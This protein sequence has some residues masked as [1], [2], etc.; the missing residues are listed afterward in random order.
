MARNE[1]NRSDFLVDVFKDGVFLKKIKLDIGKK[2]YDFV[3]LHD[4]KIFFKG[5]RIFYLDETEALIRVFEY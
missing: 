5:D 1:T 4:E 3:K 2:G